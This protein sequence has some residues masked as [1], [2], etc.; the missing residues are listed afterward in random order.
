MCWLHHQCSLKDSLF[1][2]EH[3][4]LRSS[5]PY[6]IS[7]WF[8]FI[9]LS[10]ERKREKE[11]MEEQKKRKEKKK[12]VLFTRFISSDSLSGKEWTLSIFTRQASSR[13]YSPHAL[14]GKNGGLCRNHRKHQEQF[15]W[16]ALYLQ[17]GTTDAFSLLSL[18]PGG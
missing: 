7:N 4:L 3:L 5:H 13:D 10:L 8:H 12:K 16:Q 2:I 11:R 1:R 18:R 14:L 9:L 17:K 15:R 6:I